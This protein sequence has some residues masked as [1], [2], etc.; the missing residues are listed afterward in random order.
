LAPIVIEQIFDII[1]KINLEHK[2]TIFLVEQN[3][4]QALQI[5]HRGYVM[6]NGSIILTDTAANLT[7]NEAVK[8]AYL[9]F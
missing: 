4:H 9:G 6:E 8:E 3:A 7:E 5:A 2:T 1:V